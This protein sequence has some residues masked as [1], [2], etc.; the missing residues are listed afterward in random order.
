MN[1]HNNLT[2]R[3]K[4]TN[5]SHS[6]RQLAQDDPKD[7]GSGTSAPTLPGDDNEGDSDDLIIRQELFA[8]LAHEI[9][10][11]LKIDTRLSSTAIE[12]LQKGAE[13]WL[14][15]IFQ[16]ANLEAIKNHRFTV[17]ARDMEVAQF[18]MKYGRDAAHEAQG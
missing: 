14:V 2:F 18:V 10:S 13:A 15:M 11:E 5:T 6:E 3:P 1:S 7:E 16:D 8:H 12:A 17:Q 9:F 4:E